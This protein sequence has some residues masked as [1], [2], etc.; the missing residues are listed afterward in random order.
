MSGN[1]FPFKLAL[2]TSTL[3]PFNL[4]VKQ[5][6]R[7]A[8]EAGYEGIELWVKDIEDYISGGGSLKQLRKYISDTG[9]SVVNG[10]AFFKWTDA[11]ENT[12]AEG[13]KQAER[14]M[15]MLA[16]IGCTGIAAP[17]TGNVETV[18][19]DNMARNFA[20]LAELAREIGIE[21]IIEFWGRASKLS[22]ISEAVY[23]AIESG[24]PDAKILLD[25]FHMYTGGSK[26]EALKLIDGK[27]I[28]VVHVNDYP[29][30]PPRETI[31]DKDR[32]FP[33]EGIGP[34][35]QFARLLNEA[36]YRG[37]LSLEL[38]IPSFGDK[39]ALEVASEGLEKVRKAYTV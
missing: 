24:V 28:G 11:D 36:G 32:V 27:N 9:I 22:R 18:T 1:T 20:Q 35:A 14:E 6:I 39:S 30:N 37:Y 19:L 3:F 31:A 34:T 10:I 15:R 16:E 33:G 12:R 13:F 8:A 38:F 25:L 2:N 26:V 23:I 4:D 17:P 7:V 5:Q 29:A 21:P